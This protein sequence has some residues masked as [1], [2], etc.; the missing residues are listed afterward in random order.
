[1]SDFLPGYESISWYGIGAP[2]NTPPE[3]IDRLNL[4]INAGLADPKIRT[5]MADLGGKVLAGS[6]IDFGKLIAEETAT[7]AKVVKVAGVK[8]D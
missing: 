5:R 2:K 6:A 1:L 8:P 7:W 4:E 3:I